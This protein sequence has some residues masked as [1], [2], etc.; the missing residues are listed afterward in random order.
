MFVLIQNGAV[1]QYPYSIALFRQ[2]NPNVGLPAQPTLAQLAEVGIYPVSQTGKPALPVGTAADEA[3]QLVN[4][5][6]TQVWVQ[7][8]ATPEETAQQSADLTASIVEA[9]QH[10]LNAFAQTRNYDGILSLCTYATSAVPKFQAEGQ[11]GVSARDATWA[12]LYEMLAEVQ[13]GIR[14]VPMGYA[15]IEAE[16]PQ[17][18]WPT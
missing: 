9:T 16:L 15:D 13:A 2:Q 3:V 4:G 12:K 5:Q 6:W 18:T 11:Y 14:A 8:P 10:R 1:A 17:L 7:R